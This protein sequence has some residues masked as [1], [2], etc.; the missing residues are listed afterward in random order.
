MGDTVTCEA[1]LYTPRRRKRWARCHHSINIAPD[2]VELETVVAIGR[3]LISSAIVFT[4]IACYLNRRAE[5]M[6]RL[7]CW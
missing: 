6:Q 3:K 4:R 2:I 1:G 7:L 5:L